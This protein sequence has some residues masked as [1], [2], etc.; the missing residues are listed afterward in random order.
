MGFAS[1]PGPEQGEIQLIARSV[2]AEKFH[3]RQN[4]RGGAAE[5]GRLEELASFHKLGVS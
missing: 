3:A 4:E 5:R 1:A 2:R